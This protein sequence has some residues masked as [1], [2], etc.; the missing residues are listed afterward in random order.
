MHKMGDTMATENNLQKQQ[1]Q[2]HDNRSTYQHYPQLTAEEF[3]EACHLLDSRY[4]RA[5]LGPARQQWRLHLHTALDVS[6][7]SLSV[8]SSGFITFLQI[9][10]PLDDGGFA[11]GDEL[12]SQLSKFR[13]DAGADEVGMTDAD[14]MMVS[15]EDADKVSLKNLPSLLSTVGVTGR[16]I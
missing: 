13:L 1:Q 12:A 6:S 16:N 9:A 10:R 7:S 15:M 8:A 3:A 14:A 2:G 11:A 4:C 5:T